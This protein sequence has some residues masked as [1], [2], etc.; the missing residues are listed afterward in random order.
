MTGRIHS[1]ET[2]GTLE[3]PGI[4]YV[5][6]LQG[7]PL[8]CLYCHNPDT[9]RSNDGREETVDGVMADLAGYRGFIDASGGGITCT[10]GEPLM[11][12]SFVGELFRRCRKKGVHTALDTSGYAELS[13]PVRKLLETTD[14]L[15][16]DIKHAPGPGHKE[17]TG[18]SFDRIRAFAKHADAERIPIWIRHVLVP[19]YTL[20]PEVSKRVAAFVAELASVERV[21]L[22]PYHELGRHKWE[23]LGR[24]YPLD[25]I[26]PPTREEV[27][28][29]HR[30]FEAAGLPVTPPF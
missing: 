1:I 5:V 4:R 2:M 20:D 13:E 30:I 6:F 7:C 9:W 22:L 3:G 19:G 28:A 23:A 8:R 25:T 16:L 26:A 29:A 11:Q 10:G 15:L 18:V 21:D 14:L 12:A 17:L 24:Q 27:S